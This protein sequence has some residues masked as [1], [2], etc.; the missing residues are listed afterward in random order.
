MSA[1][2]RGTETRKH[3]FY[4]TPEISIRTLFNEFSL[5]LSNI[6]VALEPSAG[7]GAIS[8][9]LKELYP[10]INLD[11][12]EI[13]EE[14]KNVLEQYGNVFIEDFLSYNS[15]KKYDLIITNPPFTYAKEFIEKSFEL[16]HENTIIIM[17]LRL[18]YLGS[19]KRHDFWKKHLPDQQ[20]TLSSRPSFTGSGT[21]AT[22]YAWFVWGTKEKLINVI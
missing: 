9:V 7:N 16:S 12:I 1:K 11:Q 22:E 20:H 18:N 5:D 3:D 17:L 8:K 10:T 14:E 4:A 19:Q 21:D 2:N 13:R 15:N 6:H